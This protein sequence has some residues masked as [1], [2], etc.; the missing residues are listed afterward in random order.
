MLVSIILFLAGLITGIYYKVWIIL[1]ASICIFFGFFLVWY[2][3]QEVFAIKFLIFFAYLTALQA[4]YLV[5]IY[6]KYG[7][8]S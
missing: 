2:I 7:R 1:Y 5:G 6:I 3:K 8:S 4:G